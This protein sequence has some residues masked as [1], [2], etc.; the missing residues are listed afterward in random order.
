MEFRRCLFQSSRRLVEAMEGEIGVDS[1]EGVG[2][3]FWF[4]LPLTVVADAAP[5]ETPP[6]RVRDQQPRRV[7]LAEDVEMN[8][9][10]VADMLRA[11]GHDVVTAANGQEAV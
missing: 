4:E 7:L 9:I 3:R 5:R 6:P 2:S 8:Q 10:L 1:L 11:H